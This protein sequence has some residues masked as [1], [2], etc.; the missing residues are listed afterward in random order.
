MYGQFFE[1]PARPLR[2]AMSTLMFA[3][4]AISALMSVGGSAV[5][6]PRPYR[7]PHVLCTPDLVKGDS[8]VRAAT[9]A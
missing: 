8:F 9:A 7:Y 1:E 6:L 5:P 2:Q 3:L 4:R